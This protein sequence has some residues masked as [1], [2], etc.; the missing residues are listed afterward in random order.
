MF[1][2]LVAG[3][4]ALT[5]ARRELPVP[6]QQERCIVQLCYNPF[7]RNDVVFATQL[8]RIAMSKRSAES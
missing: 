8:W 2:V 7:R 3:G 6:R 5:A 1:L 4:P